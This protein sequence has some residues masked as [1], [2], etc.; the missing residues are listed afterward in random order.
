MTELLPY[1][2][3]CPLVFLAGFI[4]A[5]AGGGG[6]ISI[7]A[8]ILAGLPP[9]F[10]LGTN[11]F[12]SAM[13][14]TVATWQ[15]AR[16]GYI[17]W[18]QAI[19][20]IL[21]ALIGSYIG[22]NIA[23]LVPDDTFKMVMLVILPL[24]ALYV[25]FRKKLTSDKPAYPLGKTLYLIAGLGFFIGMYDGFYGPGTGTFLMLALTG[26]AHV[27]LNDAAGITKTTNLTSN[28]A[29][30]AVFFQHDVVWLRMGIVA[31]IFS[32][33]GNY[34]GARFFTQR[35]VAIVR[36]TIFIVLTI[37]F[38]KVCCDLWL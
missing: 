17:H 7:P 22:S 31:A 15:Y 34:L 23:L 9:H 29:A 26:I 38:I 16:Q 2:I 4:D 11:K 18:P 30:L 5:I 3:V 24:I 33:V 25:T 36:P 20:S 10:A 14:T 6:L 8:Y 35:G 1:L 27:T 13:G 19:V 28:I 12:S 21:A 32:I 37:F